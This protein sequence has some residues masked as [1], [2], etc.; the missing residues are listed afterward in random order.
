MQACSDYGMEPSTASRVSTEIM[1]GAKAVVAAGDCVA[2]DGRHLWH[3][4]SAV[5]GMSGSAVRRV[6]EP[7]LLVGI[8]IG[9]T[10]ATSHRIHILHSEGLGFGA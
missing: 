9:S 5:Y 8:H 3:R 7:H 2:H 6:D 4:I 1:P 10:G